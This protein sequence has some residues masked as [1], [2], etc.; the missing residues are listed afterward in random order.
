MVLDTL[1][2]VA[3][4]AIAIFMLVFW[5][6][7]VRE[8]IWTT[9]GVLIILAVLFVVFNIG[10][11]QVLQELRDPFALLEQV[12]QVIVGWFKALFP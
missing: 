1:P 9:V 12:W 5:V 7:V 6:R 4:V 2:L 8:A 3:A 10:P 11:R